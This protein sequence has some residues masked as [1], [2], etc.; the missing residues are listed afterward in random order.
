MHA[1]RDIARRVTRSCL[2]QECSLQ[3]SNP[4]CRVFQNLCSPQDYT[5]S[6]SKPGHRV[7]IIWSKLSRNGGTCPAIRIQG[8]ERVELIHSDG[9]IAAQA[10]EI[11]QGHRSRMPAKAR[12]GSEVGACSVPGRSGR[13]LQLSP[14]LAG[15]ALLCVREARRPRRA[16]A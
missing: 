7:V 12:T 9:Q 13:V 11:R 3:Y 8:V 16:V 5:T 14:G 2:A 6:R 10:I 4:R 1:C 15:L